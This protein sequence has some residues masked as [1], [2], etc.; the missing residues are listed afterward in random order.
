MKKMSFIYWI[1]SI[2]FLVNP[3]EGQVPDHFKVVDQTVWI[4]EDLD[5]TIE[6]Y[7][8]LGFDQIKELGVQPATFKKAGVSTHVKA[9]MANLG[10]ANILWVQ[11]LKGESIFQIFHNDY[12]DGAMSLVHRFANIDVLRK[13]LDRLSDL[14]INVKEEVVIES[15][16][17]HYFIMDTHEKG[18]Y[19]LGYTYGDTDNLIWATLTNANRHNL[20]I[21]QYAFAIKDVEPASSFWRRTGL[22]EFQQSQPQIRDKIYFGRSADFEI[23]QGWQR[24]GSVVYEWCIPLKSPT[25]Y[26]DH[27]INHGEGIHHIAFSVQDMDKVIND[28]ISKG[29]EISMSG[30]WGEKNKPG[31]GRF[32]YVDMEF[33]GGLAVELLWNYR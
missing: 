1:T 17:M 9:A 4:V 25:V 18:K 8:K 20:K 29:F 19:F 2:C 11:P 32:A 3:L 13:E 14:G 12:G 27:F 28:Y 21:N 26:E 5:K 31:S 22:P 24:H 7:K 23:L 10:G 15:D 30:A 33:Y 6:G 16:A